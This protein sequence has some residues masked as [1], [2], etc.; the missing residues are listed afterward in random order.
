MTRHVVLIPAAGI[1]ARFGAACPK[2]YVSL[3]GKTVLE[4][5][6]SRLAQI[7]AI[8]LLL[9]VVSEQDAY[10]DAIYPA[11]ALPP[12]VHILRCGG[13]TRAQTVRNGITHAQQ[14]FGLQDDDWLLVHDAA[15]CCVSAD[16]V[17][18]LLAAVHNHTVG[19]LLA[20][21][22][23]DTLKQADAAQHV[24]CTVSRAGLWQAQT[25]QMFRAGILARA[26]AQA[27]LDV[28]T[29]ESSAVEALGL[30]PLLV[31]G[32]VCNL[33]LTSAQDAL[34]ATYFLQQETVG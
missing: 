32:D 34:L 25:P 17:Q 13:A 9:I 4:H 1:G 30:A 14:Q 22:V 27:D 20:L 12:N 26:L 10:I 3:A 2:Q 31:P 24:C 11:A 8:D 5:T 19:G 16:S 28:I 29:D 15:R 18:R 6:V 21:P 33:K 23:A 7:R